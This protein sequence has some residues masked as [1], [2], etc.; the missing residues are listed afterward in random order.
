M[1]MIFGDRVPLA[2]IK[3]AL[4]EA[5]D[6]LSDPEAMVDLQAAGDARKRGSISI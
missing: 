3:A 1:V 6:L 4:E 2:T 5:V